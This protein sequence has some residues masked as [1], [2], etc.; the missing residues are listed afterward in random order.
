M[1]TLGDGYLGAV[2]SLFTQLGGAWFGLVVL[3]ARLVAGSSG[4]VVLLL[5]C[6][7]NK[8][9]LVLD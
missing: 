6:S 2:S 5:R 7:R 1:G 3:G 9:E 8:V 4:A